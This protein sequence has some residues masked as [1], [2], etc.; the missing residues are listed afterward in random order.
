MMRPYWPSLGGK[1]AYFMPDRD[2]RKTY[3]CGRRHYWKKDRRER[4]ESRRVERKMARR[5]RL[6]MIVDQIESNRED[7]S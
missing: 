6:K 3:T 7:Q 1:S 2:I 5:E 4:R